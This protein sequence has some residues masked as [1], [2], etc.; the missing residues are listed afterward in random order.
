MSQESPS[1]IPISFGMVKAY[2]NYHPGRIA[3]ANLGCTRRAV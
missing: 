2:L 1:V 3:D